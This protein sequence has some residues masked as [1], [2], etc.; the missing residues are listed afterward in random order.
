MLHTPQ[1]A[2][3]GIITNMTGRPAVTWGTQ[4]TPAQNSYPAYV[5]ILADTAYDC[6]GIEIFIH[7]GAY[8]AEARDILITIGIDHAGGTTYTDCEINHLIATNCGT[9]LFGGVRYYFPLFIPA[10]SAIAAKAS[11]NNATV[12]TVYVAV[13]LYGRPTHPELVR[14]GSYV[15][16][17][18]AVTAAS[19]G[20]TITAGGVSEG[21]WTE[22]TAGDTT[23]P[24]WFW[25]VGWGAND[26]SL[27]ALFYTMDIA[28]GTA[29]AEE[30]IVSDIIHS[31]SG[32]A[33]QMVQA[34]ANLIACV[35]EVDSGK[36]IY[37]RMQCHSTADSNLSTIVYAMGG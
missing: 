7:S 33:E 16:T 21:N 1:N 6:Y 9:P 11:V 37:V 30:I 15:D 13:K 32:S 26:S 14:A 34:L 2:F 25:Q 12:R 29:G 28:Y 23:K 31:S 24:Y 27:G 22:V 18:G 19:D 10:G 35:G 3:K 17:F 36:R 20:T 4:L 8:T 5:E